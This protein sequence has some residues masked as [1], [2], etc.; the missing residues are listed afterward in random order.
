MRRLLGVVSVFAV[1]SVSAAAHADDEE[2][3]LHLQPVPAEGTPTSPPTTTESTTATVDTVHLRNGGLFR[4]RVTEIVP[5]DHVTVI[6]PSNE[7]KRIPWPEVDRVIVASTPIPPA[8]TVSA[9]PAAAPPMVG[10]K[11]RVHVTSAKRAILYR[12]PA[13]TNSWVQACQA[14]CDVDLPIGDTYRIAGNGLSQ[15]KEIHLEAGPNGFVDLVVDPP[16]TG[17][18]VIGGVLAGAGGLTGTVGALVALVGASNA[19]LDCNHYYD[20]TYYYSKDQCER[21][22]RDGPGLRDAGLVT[23]GVGAAVGVVGLVVFLNSAKTDVDQRGHAASD[24]KLDLPRDAFVRRPEWK[25]V[26]SSAESATPVPPAS[27]PLVLTG[28]F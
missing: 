19:G 25:T 11:A 7:T 12:R 14:P 21:D 26:A 15:S 23:L 17:G 6:L 5:G 27:F 2:P 3:P 13:G 24:A 9:P 4:G 20:S 10:P 8:G 28:H 16:S 1:V 22:K 18:M